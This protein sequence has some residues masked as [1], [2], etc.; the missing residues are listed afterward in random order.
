MPLQ[1]SAERSFIFEA[2]LI[3]ALSERNNERRDKREVPE[4]SPQAISP[5]EHTTA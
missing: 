4:Q 1:P 2:F 3:V 5:A